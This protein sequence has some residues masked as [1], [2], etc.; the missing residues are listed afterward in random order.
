MI[1]LIALA[2]FV[3]TC[4]GGFFALKFK[5]KLHLTLGFSAGAV[6]GLAFFDLLPESIQ[7]SG[8]FFSTSTVA[9]LVGIGFISYMVLDRLF[10]LHGCDHD[11]DEH[12]GEHIHEQIS[13]PRGSFGAGSLSV[14]SMMDGLAIGLSFGVSSG[15]GIAVAAAVLTH[16]FSDGINTVSMV[17]RHGGSK[18]K[19]LKWLAV[20]AIAPIV[21]IVVGSLIAIPEPYIGAFLA[22]FTGFFLYLGAGD[23]LPESHHRHPTHW[24]T[25]STLIGMAVMFVVVSL[26]R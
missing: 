15:L 25:I 19:A 23:L 22:V 13:N 16:D 26:T 18:L 4:L 14:H 3:A 20:D 9:L 6:L 5:D 21:G 2:T 1:Y 8:T 7:M 12:E 10:I 17:L 11:H 24:T